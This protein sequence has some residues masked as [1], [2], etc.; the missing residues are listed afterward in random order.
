MTE[1]VPEAT[2][3]PK[4]SLLSRFMGG[5]RN[6]FFTGVLV[7]APIAL[8][9]YLVYATVLWIDEKVGSVLPIR[10][11][12]QGSI[13]G[14][15]VLISVT[16]FVTV[17]IFTSNYL[18]NLL[19]EF[20]DF[21][22]ERLPLVKTIY[23]ALKQV[24]E[25]LMGNKSQAFREVV[26]VQYPHRDSWTIGFVTGKTEGEIQKV[27]IGET[28]NVFV[29]TTPNPTSG[30]LLFVPRSSV[31]PLS[32]TVDDGLKMVISGGIITPKNS[33]PERK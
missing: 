27:L 20:S 10:L 5:M 23:G 14:I 2:D 25:T 8:S 13:P 1:D 30:F 18:G 16:F 17:G 3:L 26:L 33:H 24:L 19:V 31:V 7:T 9:L 4:P 29:P 12:G 6:Y 15:G 11:A 28:I 22:M 21:V 32:M